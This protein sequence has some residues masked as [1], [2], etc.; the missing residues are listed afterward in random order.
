MFR[1]S[2]AALAVFAALPLLGADA[3][4]KYPVVKQGDV[5]DDYHGTKVKDPYRW[6]E[7]LGSADTKA[8]ID[9]QNALSS[10]VL[11]AIPAHAEVQKRLT[12]LW[13][14]PRT[15][16]PVREGGKLFYRKNSGLEKQAP[17]FVRGSLAEAPRLL[18]DPNALSPDGSLAFARSEPSPD[19]RYLA[20]CLSQGGADWEVVHVREVATGRDKGDRIEW[21]RF[22][23]ISWTK[24]SKGFFYSR[25]PEPPKGQELQAALEN[26]KLYYHRVGTPQSQ[27]RLVYERPDLPKWFLGG[28]ATEDGHYLI[29]YL[30]NGT[31]PR[32]RLY[33]ADLGDPLNPRLDAPIVKIVDEDI[34]EFR[35][36]G[37]QG[38]RLFVRTD[39]GAPRRKV[40]VIDPSLRTGRAGWTDVIPEREQPLEGAAFVGGKLFAQYLVDV[41][42]EVLTFSLE[43]KGEGRLALP[44]AGTVAGLSGRE[45]GNELFYAFTSFL[46][47]TT[48]YRYDRPVTLQPHSAER[49]K[50]GT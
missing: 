7:D 1:R 49:P 18:I 8:F 48:V 40:I 32:N 5:V 35:V 46:G 6:L 15:A 13:N 16:V 37:N 36:L 38:S 3:G 39:L 2:L 11:Q 34:A 27:D 14:Y 47:P 17:L 20:Y 26:Q 10:S 45:D 24:D 22:S 25:Y 21:F 12:A 43:G 50:S 4:L 33:Y 30:Q 41:K 28:G 44:G 29:V 31:D 42:S 19:G 9:A 23:G